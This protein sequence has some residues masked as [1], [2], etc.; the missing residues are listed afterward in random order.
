MQRHQKE[1]PCKINQEDKL[2]RCWTIPLPNVISKHI[3]H[4][5]VERYNPVEA[6]VCK[7]W[8][9][10]GE[11]RFGSTN[12]TWYKWHHHLSTHAIDWFVQPPDRQISMSHDLWSWT[13]M[14]IQLM[15]QYLTHTSGTYLFTGT[16]LISFHTL[17]SYDELLGQLVLGSVVNLLRMAEH[18]ECYF[19]N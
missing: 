2:T 1:N 4:P 16:I 14:W 19:Y 11:E 18:R 13:F 12:N 9:W 3:P 10:K 17:Y 8:I 15:C 6:I 7:V 5:S